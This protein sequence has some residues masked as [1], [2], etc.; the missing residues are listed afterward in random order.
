LTLSASLAAI[1]KEFFVFLFVPSQEISKHP[2]KPAT[3]IVVAIILGEMWKELTI[4]STTFI[5]LIFY[6]S[7]KLMEFIMERF[8]IFEIIKLFRIIH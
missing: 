6:R 3:K 8:E 5:A 1:A 2:F 4:F 7:I